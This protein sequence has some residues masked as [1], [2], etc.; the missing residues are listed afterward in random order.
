MS[1]SKKQWID[2]SANDGLLVLSVGLIC[3]LLMFVA[4]LMSI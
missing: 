2:V 1:N 4:S 3:S